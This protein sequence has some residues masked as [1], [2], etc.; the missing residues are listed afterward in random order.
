MSKYTLQDKCWNAVVL[1]N[2]LNNVGRPQYVLNKYA[3]Y[4]MSIYT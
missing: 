3:K 4:L 1:D 2:P